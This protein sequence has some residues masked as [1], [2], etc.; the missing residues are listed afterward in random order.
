MNGVEKGSETFSPSKGNVTIHT[1]ILQRVLRYFSVLQSSWSTWPRFDLDSQPLSRRATFGRLRRSHARYTICRAAL[2]CHWSF[3]KM[4][5]TRAASRASPTESSVRPWPSRFL[6]Q[7]GA[8][9]GDG[10][11]GTPFWLAP[12]RLCERKKH[13]EIRRK[14]GESQSFTLNNSRA[15]GT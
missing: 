9:K 11:A 12:F 4:K 1:K 8:A 15:W 13:K 14:E 3:S 10:E 6:Q 2:Q 7:L 5:S